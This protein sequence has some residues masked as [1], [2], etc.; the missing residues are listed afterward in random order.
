MDKILKKA[1]TAVFA[2]LL[3]AV[4][5]YADVP[6]EGDNADEGSVITDNSIQTTY[7]GDSYYGWSMLNPKGML[8][9]RDKSGTTTMF[10]DESYNII[11]VIVSDIPE[12][13]IDKLDFDELYDE[14]KLELFGY[15]PLT[16]AEKDSDNMTIHFQLKEEDRI[17][18]Y[19][20]Y[21][22]NNRMYMTMCLD[23]SEDESV[24][25]I[26]ESFSL[27]FNSEDCHDFSDIV[28]GMSVYENETFNL[29]LAVPVGFSESYSSRFDIVALTK[30]IGDSSSIIIEINSKDE[31]AASCKEYTEYHLDK[32]TAGFSKEFVNS[33]NAGEKTYGELS[34]YECTASI[35]Y[36][37]VSLTR[38]YIA[39]EHG[40]YQYRMTITLTGNPKDALMSIES[41]MTNSEFGII[42]EEKVGTIID[43]FEREEEEPSKEIK[44]YRYGFVV[45]GDV[46]YNDYTE[47][48]DSAYRYDF[49]FDM[50]AVPQSFDYKQYTDM[51]SLSFELQSYTDKKEK[52]QKYTFI[53]S[54]CIMTDD[55]AAEFGMYTFMDNERNIV[56]CLL[57]CEKDGFLYEFSFEFP[58][59]YYSEECINAM[60]NI[61]KSFKI[62]G[63]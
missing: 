16:I 35:S 55:K 39:F 27:E 38:A 40:A 1:L 4:C 29:K 24:L 45:P 22:K 5:A 36:D 15:M 31:A 19:R 51:L 49:R 21:L 30:P 50:R 28:D 8:L 3:L 11:G 52:K 37:N 34:V 32:Y 54:G 17:I 25:E 14:L 60:N 41:I 48:T 7:V 53:G 44:T 61:V 63:N 33:K 26:A 10:V 42:D 62:Y 9:S 18:D 2:V 46:D 56:V 12:E 43:I 20:V 47:F 57:I 23:S 13:A 58:E 59:A 6:D